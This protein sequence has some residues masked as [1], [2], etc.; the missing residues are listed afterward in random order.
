MTEGGGFLHTGGVDMEVQSPA[1]FPGLSR[2]NW[3]QP[4]LHTRAFPTI[5]VLQRREIQDEDSGG[6][7]LSYIK[8]FV[9]DLAELEGFWKS[10]ARQPR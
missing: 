8:V 2:L 4:R 9:Q 7:G 5:K 3:A 10:A 1:V 6:S